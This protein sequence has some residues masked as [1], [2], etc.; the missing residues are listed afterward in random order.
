MKGK[1]LNMALNYISSSQSKEFDNYTINNIGVPS[2]ILMEH[3]AQAISTRLINSSNF[4]LKKVLII[5]GTGNNGGDGIALAR[6]LFLKRYDVTIYLVGSP[7]KASQE[8][9]KQLSIVNNYGIPVINKINS[10]KGYT[11]IVDALLGVGLSRDVTGGF[12]DIVDK[13]NHSMIPIMSVDIPTGIN[14]DNGKVMGTAVKSTET[15]TMAYNKEGLG[16]PNGQKFSGV[17][18]VADIGIYNPEKIKVAKK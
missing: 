3:A 6:L 11:T 18:T 9:K 12:A 7:K 15:V 1:I 2:I 10:F 4:S 14:S 13:A 8:T 17:V 5:A 16:T